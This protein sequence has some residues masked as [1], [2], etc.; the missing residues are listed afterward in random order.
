MI[1]VTGGAGFIGSNI[2]AKL[3]SR[4]YDDIIV[5][6]DLLDGRKVH[7]LADL[8]ISDYIDKEAF[9]KK[10]SSGENFKKVDC[11]F[12]QGACSTTTEWDGKFMMENNYSYSKVLLEWAL[13]LSA[14]FYYASSAAV[15]GASQSFVEFSGAE[16]PINIYAYSKQLFD[17]YVNKRIHTFSSPVAGLRY[18]NVYGPREQHK[19]GQASVVFHAWRQ[20]Q[21]GNEI[22]LFE[23]S[24]GYGH[25]EHRR[26]FVHVEDIAKINLWMLEN[27]RV[28]GIF[29]CGT[30]QER[31]FNDLA[32]NV[33]D[34]E[35][36]G[37]IK[38]VRFP[39]ALKGSY[40]AYTRAN[41]DRLRN[42]GYLDEFTSLEMGIKSYVNWLNGSKNNLGLI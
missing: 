15:Y 26:D 35:G 1:I 38:Y 31:S 34:A 24:E 21:Q 25:G 14:P 19:G 42:I 17:K 9:L 33:I 28:S 22:A 32:R 39:T 3:N 27:S 29:N 8:E 40:Q 18:F 4:G 23:G 37:N 30:G 41:I 10:I 16:R 12:H 36:R 6:D 7:N 2:V 13:K 5:V 20:L 11:V